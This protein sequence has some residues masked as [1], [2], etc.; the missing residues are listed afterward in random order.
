MNEG[1]LRRELQATGLIPIPR[2]S[3][4][5]V[6]TAKLKPETSNRT[7]ANML[8]QPDTARK[9]QGISAESSTSVNHIRPITQPQSLCSYANIQQGHYI[10]PETPKPK[11]EQ[12]FRI[13]GREHLF[14]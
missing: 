10:K 11:Q 7:L 3:C 1:K 5:T 6:R 9:S 12:P 4:L 14:G 13:N 2:T 8:L